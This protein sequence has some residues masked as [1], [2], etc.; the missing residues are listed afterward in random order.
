MKS[1]VK[2]LLS[3]RARG[4]QTAEISRIPL[5]WGPTMLAELREK[6][7]QPIA[8]SSSCDRPRNQLK[9]RVVSRRGCLDQVGDQGGNVEAPRERR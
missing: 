6:G 9:S 4:E 3:A 5:R 8:E 7:H 1:P 2:G